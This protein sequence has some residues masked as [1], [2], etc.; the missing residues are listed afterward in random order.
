MGMTLKMPDPPPRLWPEILFFRAVFR[1]NAAIRE[2]HRRE[3]DK[4]HLGLSEFDLLVS[5]GNTEGKRMKELAA[6]M[7][8][9]PSNVTRVCA[10]MEKRGLVVRQRSDQSDREVIARLT[11]EGQALF[12]A[13]FPSISSFTQSL[14]RKG[15]A[16]KDMRAAA[17]VLERFAASVGP[18][19]GA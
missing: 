5:L 11:P 12:E 8:T 14:I 15:L 10:S 9:S 19:D 18:V 7:I 17:E 13:L 4:H 16:E 3:L 1:A 2:A 6:G